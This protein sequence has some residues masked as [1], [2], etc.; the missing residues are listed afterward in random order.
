MGFFELS[1]NKTLDEKQVNMIKSHLALVFKHEIDPS[2]GD[3]QHQI[4]LNNI[5]G[6][7]KKLRC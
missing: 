3:E 7:D 6:G 1:E 2:M 5:H 4:A